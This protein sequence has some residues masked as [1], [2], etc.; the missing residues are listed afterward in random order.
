[1]TTGIKQQKE[2]NTSQPQIRTSQTISMNT[3]KHGISQPKKRQSK[4]EENPT[5]TIQAT[6]SAA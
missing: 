1:M 5:L 3:P 4:T 2:K 6:D